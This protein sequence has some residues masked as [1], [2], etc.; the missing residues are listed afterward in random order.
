[1]KGGYKLS[2]FEIFAPLQHATFRHIWAAS[3]LSNLG[4][5]IMGVGAAW[6]MTQMTSSTSMVALVQTALMLPVALISTP[7]GAIADMF[8]RRVV[9]L[10]ALAIA[11]FG[12]LLLTAVAWLGLMSPNL[13]LALCFTVGSGMALFGPAWQASV[14]E[15]VPAE[16]LPSAVALNSISYNTQLRPGDWRGHCRRRG[17]N[18]SLRSQCPILSSAD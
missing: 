15:Q 5:L 12:A 14:S 10:V 18:R 2:K 11:V 8:D 17:R 3:L 6:S 16:A 4:L 1:M 13:L 9:G 7:A